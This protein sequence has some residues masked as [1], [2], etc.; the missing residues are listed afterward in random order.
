VSRGVPD[1]PAVGAGSAVAARRSAHRLWSIGTK[2]R[3][4]SPV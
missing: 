2:G 1:L 4:C 3:D